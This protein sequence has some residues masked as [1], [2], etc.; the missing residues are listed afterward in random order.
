MDNI[1]QNIK[2]YLFLLFRPWEKHWDAST[3]TKANNETQIIAKAKRDIWYAYNKRF[4][5]LQCSNLLNGRAHSIKFC[6]F[7]FKKFV[8]Y[9]WC[10]ELVLPHSQGSILTPPMDNAKTSFTADVG[11]TQT[12]FETRKNVKNFVEVYLIQCYMSYL[13]L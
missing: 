7:F 1:N 5:I 8:S 10:P 2:T 13:M 4:V 6:F 11:E 12:T 3:K 9:P